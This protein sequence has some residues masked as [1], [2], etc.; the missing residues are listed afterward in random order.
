VVAA[1]ATLVR[2]HACI[3]GPIR[4]VHLRCLPSRSVREELEKMATAVRFA[5]PHDAIVLDRWQLD[6]PM[7][8]PMPELRRAFE[9]YA[10]ELSNG[11]REGFRTRTREVATSEL[12]SGR[13]SM[14]SAAT[15]LGISASTLRRKLHGEHTTFRE[16]V[17]EVR[18]DLAERYLLEPGRSIGE[19]S[20]LLGF[21]YV[22]AF[23][24]AFRRWKGLS[25][26]EH[27]ARI[28]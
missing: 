2:R 20:T 1:A 22:A 23:N 24:K 17:D 16:I 28:S 25:P 11:A 12:R 10:V 27:R 5:M 9:A 7:L 3:G 26:S 19:I 14:G 6:A 21:S 4:E 13:L 8:H 18:C 15:A